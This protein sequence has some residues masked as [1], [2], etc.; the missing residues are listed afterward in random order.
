MD[1]VIEGAGRAGDDSRVRGLA[2]GARD[3]VE[4]DMG[5][6]EAVDCVMGLSAERTLDTPD[7]PCAGARA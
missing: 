5:T 3:G 1:A 4:V 2:A 7:P 6:G